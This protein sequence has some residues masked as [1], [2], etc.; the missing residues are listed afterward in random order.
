MSATAVVVAVSN[1]A[2][3]VQLLD[4]P[5]ATTVADATAETVP[6]RMAHLDVAL[7][8]LP[9]AGPPNVFGLDEPVYLTVPSDVANVA[10]PGGAVVHVGRYLRPGE[11]HG[12]WR[13]SLEHVLDVT[14]PGW[15]DH[16][17]DVR[18]VPHSLVAADHAR[19][20]TGGTRD[21]PT[22][23]VAAV[24]GLMVAG[25]WV[26]PHGMLADAAIVSGAAAATALLHPSPHR[27]TRA[28]SFVAT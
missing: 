19:V 22:I 28:R 8:T 17:V 20:A 24:P 15:R 21:R 13:G 10:P 1:P 2:R 23:D 26:G 12:D 25:D 16:V 14:Q 27:A 7:D 11:E 6:L 9:V 5:A 4:G 3:V 18:Y